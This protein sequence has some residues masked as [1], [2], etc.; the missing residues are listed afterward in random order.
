[1]RTEYPL[2]FG[3]AIRYIGWLLSPPGLGGRQMDAACVDRPNG[4]IRGYEPEV[5]K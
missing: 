2:A 5:D 4:K 1:M 3:I